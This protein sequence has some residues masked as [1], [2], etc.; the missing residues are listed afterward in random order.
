MENVEAWNKM[1]ADLVN[2]RFLLFFECSLETMEKRLLK[3]GE[4]SG[5][6]DDNPETIKKRFETF[7][8]ETQPIA[9]MYKEQNKCE[10]ADSEKPV[11]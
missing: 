7:N 2:F 11:P 8:N 6:A 1:M 10:V 9:N 5:R 3:R 4:T